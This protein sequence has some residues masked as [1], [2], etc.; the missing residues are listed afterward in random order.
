MK[1]IPMKASILALALFSA[2]AVVEAGSADATRLMQVAQAEGESQAQPE[3]MIEEPP[4]PPFDP[5]QAQPEPQIEE[6]PLPPFDPQQ[7]QPE[8]QPQPQPE[9]QIEEPPPAPAHRQGRRSSEP[10]IS[11]RFPEAVRR[12]RPHESLGL[13]RGSA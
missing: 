1:L 11:G 7:A 4:L 13:Q 3:P 12:F 5:Q 10:L 9:S 2:S 8:P 6:P